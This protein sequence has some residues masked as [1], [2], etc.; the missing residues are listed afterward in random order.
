MSVISHVKKFPVISLPVRKQIAR[1]GH[2]PDCGGPVAI[3]TLVCVNQECGFDVTP[4]IEYKRV[5]TGK[6]PADADG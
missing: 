5:I 2:C 3:V 1:S 6:E 4:L